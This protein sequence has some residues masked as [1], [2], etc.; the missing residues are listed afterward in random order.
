MTNNE[1]AVLT[2]GL[3][4]GEYAKMVRL[5]MDDNNDLHEFARIVKSFKSGRMLETTA[6]I[7]LIA[8]LRRKYNDMALGLNC[9]LSEG[10]GIEKSDVDGQLYYK[11]PAEDDLVPLLADVRVQ[12]RTSELKEARLR[13]K[14][15]RKDL[16]DA[17]DIT[18]QQSD[19]ID[20][21]NSKLKDEQKKHEQELK[22]AL[23]TERKKHKDEISRMD[24]EYSK[25]VEKQAEE[26]KGREKK[27]QQVQND[28]DKFRKKSHATEKQLKQRMT[29]L[30][31]DHDKAFQQLEEEYSI[32]NETQIN[33]Q[34]RHEKLRAELN[35]CKGI[36]IA[37]NSSS[38]SHSKIS[39]S[40][41][42]LL[43]TRMKHKRA[44][45]AHSQGEIGRMHAGESCAG[46]DVSELS[47]C[48]AEQALFDENM[49]Q[50]ETYKAMHGDVNVTFDKDPSL[51]RWCCSLRTSFRSMQKGKKSNGILTEERI[52]ALRQIGFVCTLNGS[53][54]Q[55][56]S[57]TADAPPHIPTHIL[58]KKKKKYQKEDYGEPITAGESHLNET[59][60]SE[61]RR[62]NKRRLDEDMEHEDAQS[63][64]NIRH[65]QSLSYVYDFETLDFV[66]NHDQH[67]AKQK[68]VEDERG[69][70]NES[71]RESSPT[72][73]NDIE[74]LDEKER[75]KALFEEERAKVLEQIPDECKK[76]FRTLGFGKWS[77]H[78]LPVMVLGPYDVPPG[79]LRD[80]WMKNFDKVRSE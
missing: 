10:Y 17:Q 58:M 6:I 21:L 71:E 51:F 25:K 46:G 1:M 11:S 35:K 13:L 57:T 42:D 79:P 56:S 2:E 3:E 38:K 72:V 23:K 24:K 29:K 80:Q 19:Q 73:Q 15:I 37:L 55:T 61:P 66:P 52:D 53:S 7:K 26:M 68:D 18:S 54:S 36:G 50:L 28:F 67:G 47:K 4:S 74:V 27:K 49:K 16:K 22:L 31:S 9:Y 78:Y 45:T 77:K 75:P 65:Q 8:I 40:T 32:L 60:D 59:E 48:S 12:Q 44:R 20:E 34:R 63:E 43:S 76:E 5:M 70:E 33:L 64:I 14:K 41:T 30:Q 69:N 62:S 39:G